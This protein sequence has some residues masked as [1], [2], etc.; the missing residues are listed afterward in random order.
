MVHIITDSTCDMDKETATALSVTILPLHVFFGEEEYI[1]GVTMSHRQFFDKLATVDTPPTTTQINPDTFA[2][3][4]KEVLQSPEDEIVCIPVSSKLSGTYQSAVIAAELVDKSRI[5]VVDSLN[6]TFGLALLVQEAARLRDAGLTGAEIASTVSGL[7]GKVRLYAVLDTLKY[8]K[9]G[10]RIS[11][12][13]ALMGGLM[14]I[15]PIVAVQ[16]GLVESVGKVRGQK[17]AL[18]FLRKLTEKDTIDPNSPIAF[19][20]SDAP[21]ALEQ[22]KTYFSDLAQG[23]TVQYGDIGCVVGTYAGPGASGLAYFVK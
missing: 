20:H 1:D 2:T 8:L 18:P 9:M 7:T 6:V 21:Q 23:H 12:A 11:S 5:H 16:N 10:G 13:T 3:A 14:G 17:A 19:G 4:Y 15:L 22:I